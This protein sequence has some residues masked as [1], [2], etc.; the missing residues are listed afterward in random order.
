MLSYKHTYTNAHRLYS[1]RE[2][3]LLLTYKHRI[4]VNMYVWI[5]AIF[6]TLLTTVTESWL[7]S[8]RQSQ[9]KTDTSVLTT[10]TSMI[11]IFSQKCLIL[12]RVS[13]KIFVAFLP[14]ALQKLK[15]I[16]PVP[17]NHQTKHDTFQLI[18]NINSPIISLKKCQHTIFVHLCDNV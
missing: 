2:E 16:N 8:L 17:C 6:Q 12:W 1:N 14:V 4:Y 3:L 18:L 5:V 13:H 7:H 9:N 10:L 11:Q 15:L